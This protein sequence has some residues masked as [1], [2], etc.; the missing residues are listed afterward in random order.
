VDVHAEDQLA[1][2][3]VL[4][5]VDEVAVAVAGGDPL[6]LEEAEGVGTRRPDAE[7]GLRRDPGH[8]GTELQQFALDVAGIP[9]DR[10]RDLEHRLHQLGVDPRLQLVS[11]DRTEHRVDVLDE[12]EGLAVQ[13]HVLLFDPER[14]RI[15]VAELVVEHAAAL[16]RALACDRVR[17]DL[18]HRAASIWGRTA[19]ASISTRHRGSSRPLTTTAVE[20]GRI[21]EKTSPCARA[22][23][24]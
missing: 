3:D 21:S 10:R 8:V 7:A 6:P 18:L 23:S 16:D 17:V 14:V 15:G 9:A 24:S 22:T 5:L 4:K 1:A 11:R 19:S 12:V 2:R 13:E 20:A